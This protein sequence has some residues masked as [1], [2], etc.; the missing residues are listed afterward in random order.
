MLL[1]ACG[2][3]VQV[4]NSTPPAT[5]ALTLAPSATPIPASP[6][7]P[8]PSPTTSSPR[9]SPTPTSQPPTIVPVR[10][11]LSVVKIPAPSLKDN[12]LKEPD[13][14]PVQVYLPPSYASSNLHYPVVYYLPGFG[15]SSSGENDVYSLGQIASLMSQGQLK[16]MILV[17]PNGANVL[18]GSFYVNSPVTG[19]WE[20]FIAQDV[21]GYIDAHYRTIPE[22]D[23]RGIGG[24]SMG[25]YAALYLAMRHPDLFSAVYC[26]SPGVFDE[27]GLRDSLM[28]D[29]PRKPATFVSQFDALAKLS[30][31]KALKEM[32][33]YDGPIGFTVA[34]GAAFAPDASHGPPFFDYPYE[35]KNG[36]LQLKPEVWKVWEDGFGGWPQ[37]IAKYHQGLA[38]LHGI[39]IDYATNDYGWIHTG[40]VYLSQLLN[41]AGISN[42]IYEFQGHHADHIEEQLQ[43]VML[44]FFNRGLADPR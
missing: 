7:S 28:F 32:V 1:I 16:E 11:N 13:E 41:A 6:T 29:S 9:S 20:D 12:L 31:D 30:P 27:N 43:T 5:H 35:M 33:H 24:H 17:V 21:V 4:G 34:Y 38:S 26:L 36:Q 42:Q 44:P 40:S 39:V 23:G 14:Q 10:L 8:K 15:S 3:S 19:N 22:A 37:K 18:H 2:F 25:G